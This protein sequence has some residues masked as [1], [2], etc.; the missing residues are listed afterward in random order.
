[1]QAPSR[2][3]FWSSPPGWLLRTWPPADRRHS[4]CRSPSPGGGPPRPPCSPLPL[5]LPPSALLPPVSPLERLRVVELGDLAR[6]SG[7]PRL[8]RS[9]RQL[10]L[11]Q[12]HAVVPPL[13]DPLTVAPPAAPYPYRTH[14]WQARLQAPCAVD[15]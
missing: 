6:A 5:P 9:D 2:C 1:M 12:A 7:F 11:L 14:N 4:P 8:A 3:W 13:P 10:E 15:P